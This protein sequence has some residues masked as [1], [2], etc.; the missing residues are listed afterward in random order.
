MFACYKSLYPGWWLT[1]SHI[2]H[3]CILIMPLW[4]KL[5]RDKFRLPSKLK[6]NSKNIFSVESRTSHLSGAGCRGRGGWVTIS[7][8]I[9]ILQV[10]LMQ[11]C[12]ITAQ[13]LLMIHTNEQETLFILITKDHTSIFA[14]FSQFT[15]NHSW[16]YQKHIKPLFDVRQF[17]SSACKVTKY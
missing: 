15:T 10:K 12:Q 8:W 13:M 3:S 4:I 17:W 11:N 6:W 9:V 16:N 2:K 7:H 14:C 1:L 5:Q